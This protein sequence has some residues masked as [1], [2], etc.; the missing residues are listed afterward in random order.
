MTRVPE[1]TSSISTPV[2]LPKAGYFWR[3]CSWVSGENF[4]SSMDSSTREGGGFFAGGARP[5]RQRGARRRRG[6][7]ARGARA[8]AGEAETGGR[9]STS[10]R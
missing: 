10:S 5:P 4:A 6:G 2:E 9:F 8:A 7:G 3:S 1:G